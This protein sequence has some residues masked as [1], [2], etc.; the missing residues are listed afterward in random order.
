MHVGG[1][2]Q[3]HLTDRVT[4]GWD[5]DEAYKTPDFVFVF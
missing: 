4:S 5:T 1:G 3:V 2:T